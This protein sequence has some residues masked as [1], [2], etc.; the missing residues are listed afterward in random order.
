MSKRRTTY[1]KLSTSVLDKRIG[2]AEKALRLAAL[3]SRLDTLEETGAGYAG[4][5]TS[6]RWARNWAVHGGTPDEVLLPDREML[7]ERAGDLYRNATIPRSA[8]NTTCESAIGSGLRLQSTLDRDILGID[9]ETAEQ[10][11]NEIERKFQAWAD[12][13]ECD[14]TRRFTFGQIQQLAFKAQQIEGECFSLLPRFR[15]ASM[16]ARMRVQL[17]PARR[18][19]N[20]YTISTDLVRDGITFNERGEPTHYWFSRK[21]GYYN[22]SQDYIQV[23]AFGTSSGRPNVLH[24]FRPEFI[25]QSR[26]IPLLASVMEDL[27]NIDRYSK[28]ELTNAAVQALF[29]GFVKSNRAN[30][31]DAPFVGTDE[32]KAT[33]RDTDYILDAGMMYHLREGEEV[34]FADPTRPSSGFGPF[35]DT[36]IT[37]IAA[38][39]GLTYEVLIKRFNSSFS[40]S[41]ASRIE[42]W[43]HFTLERQNFCVSFC[44]PIFREWMIESVAYG[45]LD[46]PGFFDDPSVME[47][48]LSHQW[49]GDAQGQ[50]DPTKETTAAIQKIGSA[51]STHQIEAASMGHDFEKNIIMIKRERRLLKQAGIQLEMFA[52]VAQPLLAQE[53]GANGQENRTD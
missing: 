51:L 10:I 11:E 15:R 38:A 18:C 27:K 41:K 14:A 24:L 5:S 48:Y 46:L 36:Y 31:L 34:Q 40:A 17:L 32:A 47:A 13:R 4:A 39:L 28:A 35:I 19:S 16:E 21:E 20:P 37:L 30:A 1:R 2:R 29:T 3:D 12:S 23:K 9:D 26:G 52:P 49:F 22:L 53:E 6:R 42:A 44:D 7:V 43:R 25:G 33:D 45:D 50:I 8:I